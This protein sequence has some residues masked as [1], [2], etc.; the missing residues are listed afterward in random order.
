MRLVQRLPLGIIRTEADHGAG[1]LAGGG[2][3]QIVADGGLEARDTAKT[4]V[5]QGDAVGQ[6]GFKDADRFELLNDAVV[7]GVPGGG[8]FAGED[9]AF[10]AEAVRGGVGGGAFFTGVGTRAGGLDGHGVPRGVG[11]WAMFTGQITGGGCVGWRAQSGCGGMRCA[12]GFL[13]TERC[14]EGTRRRDS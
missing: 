13:L 3:V 4:P 7:E 2:L 6:F 14:G 5:M 9:G 1:R 8:I 11:W 12:G 10:G